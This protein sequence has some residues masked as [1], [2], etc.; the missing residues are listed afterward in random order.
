MKRAVIA[1][2]VLTALLAGCGHAEK[3]RQAQE[4]E[5][6]LKGSLGTVAVD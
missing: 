1:F 4:Y 5:Q 6:F 3:Q 2:V